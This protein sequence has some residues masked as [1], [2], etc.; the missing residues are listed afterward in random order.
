[1]A[2]PDELSRWVWEHRYRWR[3]QAPG[4]EDDLQATWR[5]VARAVAAAEPHQPEVW[6]DRFLGLLK[7]FRFLPAGRILANAGTGR[8]ATLL[9]CFVMGCIEDSM[10]GICRALEES[11]LTLQQGGGIGLDFSTLRPRGA[12]ATA[13][14]TIASGPVSFMRIWNTMCA[15]LLATGNRRGAMMATLRCDHPD[16][17][18]FI[19]AKRD[20][21]ALRFFNLSVAV[22]DEFMAAVRS[23][24]PWSLMFPHAE[25]RVPGHIHAVVRARDIWERLLAANYETAEPGV[26]FCDTINSTNNLRWRETLTTT[27]PCGEAPLPPHGACNLGSINL[28]RFV[29]RPFTPGAELDLHA[30]A[31]VARLAVRFLDDVLDVT[32]FP[33]PVQRE[34]ALA[35]RRIGLGITGLADALVMV[36]LRYDTPAARD[37]AAAAMRVI[38]VNAYQAS[39]ALA[40]EKGPFPALDTG[41]YLAAP[42]V[43]RLPGDIRRSIEA[44]GMRNSHVTAIA[45]A[46]TISLLAG[47]VAS[48]IEPMFGFEG[49]RVVLGAAGEPLEFT[50]MNNA[51]RRW[52][53]KHGDSTLPAA[54]VTA[55]SLDPEAHL[56]MQAALQPWV[57]GAI[58]KTINLPT[59]FPQERY[60]ELFESAH[61]LGLKGCTTYRPGTA[62]GQVAGLGEPLRDNA[63]AERCCAV[64]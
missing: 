64:A 2:F 63:V 53:E 1:M 11:A 36:G 51:V 50:V 58:A 49:K 22:S 5:R 46:G 54:F 6:E 26:Q 32:R 33:L 9:N 48:G 31:E 24:S 43:R 14:G 17:L 15:T 42:N 60:W 44:D 40:A 38:C 47:N 16:I 20:P 19:D 28:S 59:T 62:R 4:R 56:Q 8:S 23:D 7:D 10:P 35:S 57:D 55:T 37:F 27:N 39:S 12:G 29:L 30:I 25:Q 18:E 52:H 61:R 13:S 45:P 34:T 3:P 41:R 21:T